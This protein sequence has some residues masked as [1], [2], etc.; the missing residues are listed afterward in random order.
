MAITSSGFC[1]ACGP[2]QPNIFVPVVGTNTTTE[3][4][5]TSGGHNRLPA[6]APS[7]PVYKYG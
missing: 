5:I 1:A 6:E 3:D 4:P 2:K 7:I